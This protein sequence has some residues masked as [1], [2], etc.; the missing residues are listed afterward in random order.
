MIKIK[1]GYYVGRTNS[2]QFLIQVDRLD[3]VYTRSYSDEESSKSI[4]FHT[5]GQMFDLLKRRQSLYLTSSKE[6]AFKFIKLMGW[7][8]VWE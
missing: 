7:I 2:T 1:T 8:N 6:K 4:V 3:S 5:Q